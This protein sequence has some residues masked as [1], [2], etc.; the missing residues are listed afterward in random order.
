MMAIK[1]SFTVAMS[2]A[3]LSVFMHMKNDDDERRYILH[4]IAYF[5]QYMCF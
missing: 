1:T 4:I 5:V 3:L 2:F